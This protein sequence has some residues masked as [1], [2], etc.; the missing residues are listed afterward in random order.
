M[1]NEF[2]GTVLAVRSV[3]DCIRATKKY[4]ESLSTRL[5]QHPIQG[6]DTPSRVLTKYY[7]VYPD[8]EVGWDMSIVDAVFWLADN[9]PH[10]DVKFHYDYLK[11]RASV[12]V[13]GS[14]SVVEMLASGI[15]GL[16]A[17]LEKMSRNGHGN[18]GKVDEA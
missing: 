8:L 14:S 12:T 17:A 7:E 11:N 6:S 3:E 4:T 18:R 1:R 2:T 16:S 9:P 5:A 10:V 15:P 13:L